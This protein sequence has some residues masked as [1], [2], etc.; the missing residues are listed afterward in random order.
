[1]DSPFHATVMGRPMDQ[2]D[3]SAR[4]DRMN[5][6][7]RPNNST[8][9]TSTYND[10]RSPTQPDLHFPP[11]SNG[12]HPR[13]QFTSPYP[14]PQPT[15]H[16]PA[17]PPSPRAQGLP[18]PPY[19]NEYQ[20]PRE[21][22]TSNYYDPTSDSSERR[23]AETSSWTDAQSNAAPLVWSIHLQIALIFTSPSKKEQ[24]ANIPL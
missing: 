20:P 2:E 15:S 18:A 7:S 14:P 13:P 16:I 11:S 23:P 3:E 12:V 5:G 19:Q 10:A 6:A 1:M 4:R 21:K 9:T 22:P 8:S 24:T 17:L